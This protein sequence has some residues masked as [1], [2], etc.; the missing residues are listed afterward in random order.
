MVVDLDAEPATLL[1]LVHPDWLTWTIEGHLVLESLVRLDSRTGVLTGELAESWDVDPTGTRWTFHLRKGVEWHDGVAASLDDV[2]FTF[3]RLLDPSVG[4]PDRTLFVGARVSKVG[5]GDVEVKLASPLPSAALAFDRLLILPRHRFPRGDLSRSEDASGPMG[6]GPMRFSSWTRGRE[7]VLVRNK[8]YWGPKAH[9]SQ[10]T[11]RFV[12]SHAAL[13]AALDHGDVDIVPRASVETAEHV[14]G[15][16]ALTASYDVVRAGG[17]DYT[18]WIQNVDSPKLRDA[19][20][21]RAIGLAIPRAQIRSEV[22]RCGVQLASG[23][24]PPGHEALVGI[25]PPT[26]D[27]KEAGRLLDEAGVSDNNGDGIREWGGAPARFTLIYPSSSRQQERSATVVADELRRLGVVLELS[28]IEWA[29]FLRRVESHDF[30]LASIEWSIDGQPDLY[31]LF[32]SSQA[33]GGLNYGSYANKEVD[34]WLDDL[35]TEVRADRRTELLRSIVERLRAD[36]PYTFLFSPI[37]QAIVRRGAAGVTP[38]PLGWQP[39]AWG[40]GGGG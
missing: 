39:R 28:P 4:A 7:I 38:T 19:R 13:L 18:A 37:V 10:M 23:P 36:E 8:A 1:A 29:E 35:R 30:E 40:W 34:A 2:L 33:A 9:L 20:V 26:F 6:T 15:N 31:P 17:F 3:D 14:E 11:F 25:A 5:P 24:L 32:H 16:P 21:R 27:P 12:P 22:E